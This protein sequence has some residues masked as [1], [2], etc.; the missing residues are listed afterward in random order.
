MI[1]ICHMYVDVAL[2][3]S[4]CR[5]EGVTYTHGN[6]SKYSPFKRSDM[7]AWDIHETVCAYARDATRSRIKKKPDRLTT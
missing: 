3:R 4:H 5:S 7:V 6:S 2:Q 1:K